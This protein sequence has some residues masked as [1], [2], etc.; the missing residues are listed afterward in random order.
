MVA[1]RVIIASQRV[2]KP[3]EDFT[4]GI[5]TPGISP[6]I[7]IQCLSSLPRPLYAA[8][9]HKEAKETDVKKDKRGPRMP[10]TIRHMMK[11]KTKASGF[12]NVAKMSAAAREIYLAGGEAAHVEQYFKGFLNSDAVQK[13]ERTKTALGAWKAGKKS[14]SLQVFQEAF[15]DLHDRADFNDTSQRAEFFILHLRLGQIIQEAAAAHMKEE[16][17]VLE[18]F[19][20]LAEVQKNRTLSYYYWLSLL[21]CGGE[22][23]GGK[24]ADWYEKHPH[25]LSSLELEMVEFLK[26]YSKMDEKPKRALFKNMPVI[27][28]LGNVETFLDHL[29]KDVPDLEEVYLTKFL[30]L[31]SLYLWRA[32]YFSKGLTSLAVVTEMLQ[33]NMGNLEYRVQA[34]IP[35]VRAFMLISHQSVANDYSSALNF[36]DIVTEKL[37]NDYDVPLFAYLYIY[38]LRQSGDKSL[39]VKAE[40]LEKKYPAVELFKCQELEAKYNKESTLLRSLF[41][42]RSRIIKRFLKELNVDAVSKVHRESREL[43]KKE[44]TAEKVTEEDSSDVSPE[45]MLQTMEIKILECLKNET[46]QEAI[47]GVQVAFANDIELSADIVKEVIKRVIVMN[48]DQLMSKLKDCLPIQSELSDFLYET[49]VSYKLNVNYKNWEDGQYQESLQD[50]FNVYK[51]LLD[52]DYHITN[53]ALHKTKTKLGMYLRLYLEESL[54]SRKESLTLPIIDSCG[55]ILAKDF[56]DFSWLRLM[57]EALFFSSDFEL[58]Q[59]SDD[60]LTKFP[61]LPANL[62]VDAMLVRASKINDEQ[63]YRRIL[64][65]CLQNELD[66]YEKTRAYEGLLVCQCKC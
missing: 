28:S 35:I 50:I 5:A 6:Q 22:R 11:V 13:L 12:P 59:K 16:M 15:W 24:A 56:D 55:Q 63:V 2:I 1:R 29:I 3:K 61:S 52:E 26:T 54:Q 36:L 48:D 8:G 64:E 51:S 53:L 33:K 4:S 62:D 47:E 7:L 60:L 42:N 65:V 10:Q 66:H 25:V 57:W 37:A 30:T 39:N 20:D 40:L 34:G 43:L 17:D 49:D 58:Q 44:E 31:K 9:I 38:M 18:N 23:H 19:C 21:M 46:I 14:E 27:F 45:I 32:G 41:S